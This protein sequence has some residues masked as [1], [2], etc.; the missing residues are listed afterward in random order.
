MFNAIHKNNLF[1]LIPRIKLY[2]QTIEV[3]DRATTK[4][5]KKTKIAVLIP[6]RKEIA[7]KPNK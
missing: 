4:R 1:S 6:L 7:M 2:V 5:N 3:P